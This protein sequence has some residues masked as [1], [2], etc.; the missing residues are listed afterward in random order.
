MSSAFFGLVVPSRPIDTNFQCLST[1]HLRAAIPE[2]TSVSH[3]TVFSIMPPTLQPGF[4][5]GVFFQQ[6]SLEPICIGALSAQCYS[7]TTSLSPFLV[8]RSI[9]YQ[10]FVHVHIIPQAEYEVQRAR[11]RERYESTEQNLQLAQQLAGRLAEDLL[12]Y[13]S[14]YEG[15]DSAGGQ[16]VP[17][18]VLTQWASTYE[19]R[20]KYSRRLWEHVK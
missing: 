12:L 15:G 17:A 7:V 5:Y 16:Y 13:A 14:S 11:A 9:D 2:V 18:S 3:L 6:G 20:L 1:T 4:V 8:D 10:G 19:T